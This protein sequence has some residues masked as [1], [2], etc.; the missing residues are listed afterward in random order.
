VEVEVLVATTVG[1]TGVGVTT[2]VGRGSQAF[3]LAEALA[4]PPFNIQTRLA[5]S[6]TT[7][8]MLRCRPG[9]N[10][11]GCP[12]SSGPGENLLSGP[13]GMMTGELS[14]FM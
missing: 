8:M 11:L 4:E 14:P 12:R 9:S 1:V 13:I 10:V 3:E 6:K 5:L 2:T 7:P